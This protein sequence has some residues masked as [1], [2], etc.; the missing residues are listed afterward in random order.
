MEGKYQFYKKMMPG[1]VR[2]KFR[3]DLLD[4]KRTFDYLFELE[5][6]WHFLVN[7]HSLSWYEE[8]GFPDFIV[9]TS[10]FDFNVE[11]KRITVDASRKTWRS[12]FCRLVEKFL[13]EV[14]KLNY[15]GVIEVELN[16]RLHS[17]NKHIEQLSLQLL[18]S[19]INDGIQG[20]F[21]L[22]FGNV[23]TNLK[24]S[25]GEIVDFKEKYQKMWARKAH[26][27]HGVIYASEK[28]GKPVNPIELTLKSRKSEKVLE[29]IKRILNNH[30]LEVG[31]FEIAD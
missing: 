27:A 6:A 30:R 20:T 26:E 1:S 21:E 3:K 23:S 16:D 17:N 7:N 15:K 19:I 11:C 18:K 9:K 28:N 25:D 13:P 5:I 12:D 31:G 4:E 24:Q 10:E 14:K 22:S 29:G 8:D 2:N